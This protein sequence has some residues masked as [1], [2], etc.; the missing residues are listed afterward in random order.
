MFL[1]IYFY[2]VA[3]HE[4]GHSLGLAH[5]SVQSSIMFPYYKNN[6]EELNLDYDDILGIYELYSKWR[7]YM[8]SFLN[9]EICTNT[10]TKYI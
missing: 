8:Y 10:R 9:A 7:C 5:S 2:A 6:P 1:G 4:L 3:L